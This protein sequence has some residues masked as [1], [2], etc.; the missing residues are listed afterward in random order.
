MQDWIALNV[1][2]ISQLYPT[3][4]NNITIHDNHLESNLAGV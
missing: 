3:S 4:R 2:K 1:D